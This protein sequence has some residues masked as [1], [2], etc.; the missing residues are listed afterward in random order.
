MSQDS[1]SKPNWEV[2]RDELAD[3]YKM[4]VEETIGQGFAEV[5]DTIYKAAFD[6][7]RAEMQ[8]ELQSQVPTCSKCN[9]SPEY[10]ECSPYDEVFMPNDRDSS[11][12]AEEYRKRVT[13]LAAARAEIS[14]LKRVGAKYYNDVDKLLQERGQLQTEVATKQ[15]EISEL[16]D[17]WQ[18]ERYQAA[19]L[20]ENDELK[21]QLA[22]RDEVIEAQEAAI[23]VLRGALDRIGQCISFGVE[24][25]LK[26]VNEALEKA[27][28]L[29]AEP[30]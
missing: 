7:C 16:K 22:K 18:K 19:V 12:I 27:D 1:N 4:K 3:K 23:K 11:F 21:S 14:E 25:R 2:K 30:K 6:D 20:M 28:A 24:P 8:S 17:D 10:S 26:V 9:D 13:E 15:A 29:L 5:C